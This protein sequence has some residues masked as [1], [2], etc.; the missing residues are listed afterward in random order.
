METENYRKIL[1]KN[2]SKSFML[3]GEAHKIA[4]RAL[5]PAVQSHK[6]LSSSNLEKPL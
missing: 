2:L 6:L 5:Q 3:E 4:Q 1:Q